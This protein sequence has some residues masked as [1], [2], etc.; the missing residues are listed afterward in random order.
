M[1]FSRQ[2]NKADDTMKTKINNLSDE[3]FILSRIEMTP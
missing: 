1:I 2:V 3:E